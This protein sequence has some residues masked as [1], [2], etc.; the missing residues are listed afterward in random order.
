MLQPHSVKDLRSDVNCHTDPPYSV[1]FPRV[2]R[3]KNPVE[4]SKNKVCG[5]DKK[6][7]RISDCVI[8]YF[9]EFTNDVEQTQRNRSRGPHA[10]ATRSVMRVMK[11]GFLSV[12]IEQISRSTTRSN[13]FVFPCVYWKFYHFSSTHRINFCKTKLSIHVLIIIAIFFEL[14]MCWINII[15]QDQSC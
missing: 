13:F 10:R 14:H 6:K 8:S 3:Y 15:F 4:S 9:I 2:W 11:N 5:P 12:E 1:K 7:E